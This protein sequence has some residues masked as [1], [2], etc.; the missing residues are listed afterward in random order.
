MRNTFI[1]IILLVLLAG[2]SLFCLKPDTTDYKINP[3]RL[4][5]MYKEYDVESTEGHILKAW[6][7]PAQH[8]LPHDSIISY[9][10]NNKSRPYTIPSGKHPTIIIANGDGGNM[11]NLVSYAFQFC[12]EGF[13]VITFDWRGFG[14]SSYFPTD[15]NDLVYKEYIVDY[16]AV[17]DFAL[18]HDFVDKDKIGV[19][20]FSTGAFLSYAIAHKRHEINV[21]L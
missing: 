13:N 21:Q 17:V 20:G 7:Y 16:N 18:E 14:K 3:N 1:S 2:N 15:T 19:L 12:T 10:Y 6:F 11:S 8:K 9:S 4:G 5:L